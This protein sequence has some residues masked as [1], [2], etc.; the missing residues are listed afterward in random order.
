MMMDRQEGYLTIVTIVLIV[1]VGFIAVT[2]AYVFSGNLFSTSNF[3]EANSALYL[4][5][6]GLEQAARA[7]LL[8]DVF[9]RSAC[10]G[11]NMTNSALGN[12]VYT[13]TSTGPFNT[14]SPAA[15]LSGAL[16]ASA[17]TIPVTSTTGYQS[18][19]RI[20]V[21]RE[22]INYTAVNSTQFLNATRGVDGSTAIAHAAATAVGQYQCAFSATGGVPAITPVSA[23]SPG[24]VRK[25]NENIQLQEA[26]VVGDKPV[27]SQFTFAQWNN[28][29]ELAWNTTSFASASAVN[30]K[31]ITMLSYAD[32]WAAGDNGT[33]LHWDGNAW[34][35]QTPSGVP[36]VTMQGI[37]CNTSQ[38]CQAV[39][40][41]SG[42]NPVI[43]RWNGSSWTRFTPS[44]ASNNNLFS[45]RCD[46]SND[47][48]A[49]GS[50]TGNNFYQWN[51][52]T[53]STVAVGSLSGFTFNSVYCNSSTDCWAAGS[54]N[55][56]ARKNGAAWADASVTERGSIPSAVY[57]SVFC[58][59]SSDCWAVGNANA[60]QDLFVH[61]NGTSWSR[62]ASTP[63]PVVNL[64][65]VK[66]AAT[67]DCWAV[68]AAS[69]G[70]GTFFHWDGTS[71]SN[72]SVSGMPNTALNS[73][74][75]IAPNSQ[76]WSN[77]SENFS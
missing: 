7:L 53:W 32:G 50:S 68:G 70:Q 65:E 10:T 22:L 54:N 3:Q 60:S 6:S 51:G 66:C 17:T 49:V 29:T 64:N 16:T 56:F 35:A 36:S 71:W 77:W 63:S 59:S 13:V 47:C 43:V 26:W 11:L 38:D 9:N 15:T 30:L 44:G 58:N 8:P 57:N 52:T 25:L 28:P 45:V 40:Q 72:V 46:A 62:D 5:E 39:G 20:M 19:G 67:N 24:G 73:I 76:P 14:P 75:I 21:D 69:G 27:S 18:S 2:I 37:Y 34:T 31:S 74:S 48:W 33:F 12:G 55:I 4:A 1:I 23:G 42:G 41:R 61:W